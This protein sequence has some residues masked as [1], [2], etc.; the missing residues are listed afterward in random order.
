MQDLIQLRKEIHQNPELSGFEKETA[1]RVINFI[2]PFGPDEI[3]TNVGGDG[4][5]I[6][7]N[8]KEPGK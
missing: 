6:V 1:K 8:G 2:K 4:I 7:F 3:I 5:L